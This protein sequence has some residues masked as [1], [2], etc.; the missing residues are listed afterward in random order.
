M[1]R[2]RLVAMIQT[3]ERCDSRGEA[4][5]NER[6]WADILDRENKDTRDSSLEQKQHGPAV[7]EGGEVTR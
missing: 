1:E 7:V 6:D 2:T 3:T 5:D 4:T